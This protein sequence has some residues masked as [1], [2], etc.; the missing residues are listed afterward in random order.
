MTAAAPGRDAVAVKGW[1]RAHKWLIVR[2]TSQ[3]LILALFFAGPLAGLWILDGNLASSRLLGTV[4][5]T[6]PFVLSQQLAAGY[7]P[8]ASALSGAGIMLLFYAL[9]GGRVFCSW[10]CPVNIVT[11]AACWLRARLGLRPQRM[12]PRATR[13]WLLAGCLIAAALTGSLIWETVNPVTMLPRGLLFGMGW[14]GAIIG[15]VF[16]YDLLVAH[17]GW[18]GHLCPMGAFYGLVGKLSL[19]RVSAPHRGACTDCGECFTA[20]PEPQVIAPALK[21]C[22]SPLVLDCACTNCGRCIDVCAERVFRMTIRFDRRIDG[23]AAPK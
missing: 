7:L 2:R 8:A 3:A 5:L 12:P 10:V 9:V 19:V 14:G 17:R 23:A 4:T 11:D 18:C 21:G 22:G 1:W 16:A 6:D 15:A 20:C 13:H